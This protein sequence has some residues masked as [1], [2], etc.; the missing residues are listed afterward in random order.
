VLR[1][2]GF[3]L[4]ELPAV[5]KGFTLIELLVV[6]AIISLLVSILL[7]SLSRAKELAR[8]AVCMTHMRQQGLA[9]QLYTVECN[10][11]YPGNHGN[12][13]SSWIRWMEEEGCLPA[14]TRRSKTAPEGLLLCPSVVNDKPGYRMLC[15]YG[16]T[17]CYH[18][19]PADQVDI[20]SGGLLITFYGPDR[21]RPKRAEDVLSGSVIVIEKNLVIPDAPDW[22]IQGPYV[23]AYDWNL[24]SRTGYSWGHYDPTYS[25][26]FRHNELGNFMFDDFHIENYGMYQYFNGQWVPEG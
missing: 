25:A 5:R 16:P 22:R 18:M 1:R 10:G 23:N 8:S 15:S 14:G 4:I 12:Q 6:V 20:P 7:P 17:L 26:A 21:T 13:A 2:Q 19:T 3:T 24:P 11:Y 9:L